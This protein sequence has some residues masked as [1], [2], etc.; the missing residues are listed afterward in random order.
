[1]TKRFPPERLFK[2]D[3]YHIQRWPKIENLSQLTDNHFDLILLDLHGVG[4]AESPQRAGLGILQHIKQRSP[5]QL[6]IA[7]SAQPWKI[8]SRDFF[9][10]ADSVLDKGADYVNFKE[11]VDSLL[12]RRHSVGYFINKMNQELGDSAA[13]APKAVPKALRAVRTGSTAS[14]RSYLEAKVNEPQTVD[15]VIAIV[16]LAAQVVGTVA[17]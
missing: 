1:M 15:R 13:N 3:G 11:E 8:S 16:S 17:A 4:L 7:Y 9:A 5:T 2:R 12:L 10:L 6:V 14:L